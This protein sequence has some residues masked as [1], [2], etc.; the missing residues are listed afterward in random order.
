MGSTIRQTFNSTCSVQIIRTVPKNNR[1][2]PPNPA[3]NDLKLHSLTT[4]DHITKLPESGLPTHFKAYKRNLKTLSGDFHIN[5][6]LP[7]A[8]LEAHES[9]QTWFHIHGYSIT[10]SG[11]QSADMVRI[12]FLARVRGF[13]YRD[14]LYNYIINSRE[15]KASPF[16]LRLY[17]DSFSTNTK[18]SLT[19]VLMIVVDPPNIDKALHFFH[20]V[21]DGKKPSS[22]NHIPYLFLPLYRKSYSDEERVRIIHNTDHHTGGVNVVAMTGLHALENQIELANGK[23]VMSRQL[24]LAIPAVDTS[25]G[26][27]FIQ[28]E[29]QTGSDW[30]ICCFHSTDSSKVTLQLSHLE[31]LLQKSVKPEKLQTLF[32]SPNFSIKFNGQAAT[33]KKGQKSNP[34]QR[35]PKHIATYATAALS[36]L[37]SPAQK[38]LAIDLEA[39]H[40]ESRMTSLEETSLTSTIPIPAPAVT[41]NQ[42]P[43]HTTIQSNLPLPQQQPPPRLPFPWTL[44]RQTYR[45][46]T[47]E[48]LPW[49][50]VAAVLL[51]PLGIWSLACILC[52]TKLIPSSRS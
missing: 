29:C 26:K 30:L 4:A 15:W 33:F 40:P 16:H 22:P 11:C 9:L 20:T 46:R 34:V 52:I 28:V 14:D 6:S 17:F 41:P 49:K 5:T 21:Y 32:S 42:W 25:T 38:R 31:T 2:K 43:P 1:C 51:R 39:E 50:N 18:G 37:H 36:N 12:G 45:N 27:L 3:K 10:F 48:L 47:P 7:F 13:T 23:M 19:Y 8:Q 24:L 44:S 35:V